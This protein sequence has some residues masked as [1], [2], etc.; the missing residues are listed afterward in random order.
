MPSQVQTPPL[1]MHSLPAMRTAPN[2]VGL[3]D[4]TG[5]MRQH[6]VNDPTYQFV[7][8]LV[9]SGGFPESGSAP[10]QAAPAPPSASAGNIGQPFA[11]LQ[12]APSTSSSVSSFGQQTAPAPQASVPQS[13]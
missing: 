4:R 5:I 1:Q 12:P 2:R 6:A 7:K 13:R 11:A 10:A 3:R 9:E 8:N